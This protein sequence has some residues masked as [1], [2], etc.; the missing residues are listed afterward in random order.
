MLSLDE[1]RIRWYTETTQLQG[2]GAATRG[3]PFR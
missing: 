2:M 3:G 1:L